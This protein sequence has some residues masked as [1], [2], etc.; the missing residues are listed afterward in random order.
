MSSAKYND[1]KTKR[2]ISRVNLNRFLQVEEKG[3]HSRNLTIY[4][5]CTA[6]KAPN[7]PYGY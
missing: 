3:Q 6:T 4:N 1:K 7:C 5:D 2:D